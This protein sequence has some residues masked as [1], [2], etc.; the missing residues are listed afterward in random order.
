M[1]LEVGSI[2]VLGLHETLKA[3]LLSL[4]G[5]RRMSSTKGK[6]TIEVITGVR[7]RAKGVRRRH[8]MGGYG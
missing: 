4:S 5:P 2:V 8:G 7:G 3:L 6:L 1:R